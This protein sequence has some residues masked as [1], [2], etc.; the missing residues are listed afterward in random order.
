M[1]SSQFPPARR[2]RTPEP[3]RTLLRIAINRRYTIRAGAGFHLVRET[4]ALFSKSAQPDKLHP[5]Q[6]H[7]P[8]I[9]ISP[10]NDYGYWY[11]SY[12]NTCSLEAFLLTLPLA[13]KGA[14]GSRAIADPHPVCLFSRRGNAEPFD[15]SLPSLNS[16]RLHTI[17]CGFHKERFAR[18]GCNSLKSGRPTQ[19]RCTPLPIRCT[20]WPAARANEVPTE[21]PP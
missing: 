8:E 15:R 5:L 19:R 3:R 16:P 9:H 10:G 11:F 20:V 14:V 21:R 17:D 4:I 12:F 7:R 13:L 1:A 2:A 6:T 18:R